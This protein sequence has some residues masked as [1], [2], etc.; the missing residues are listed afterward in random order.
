MEQYLNS[1]DLEFLLY[2]LLDTE[3][4]LLR[5]RY[6]QHSRAV[7]DATLEAAQDIAMKYLAPHYQKGDANEPCFDGTRV[8]VIAETKVAWDVLSEAGFLGAHCDEHEGGLQVPEIVCRAANAYF[9]AAN[10]PTAWYSFLTVGVINLIRTFGS[11]E[12]KLTFLPPLLAGRF[13]GTMALTEAGQGSALADI[14]TRAELQ[15]DG[16]WLI[17]GQKMFITA[18]DH[19]LTE[20]IVHLVL[21]RAKGAP[22]G[23]KGISLFIVPKIKLD[24][25]GA[26]GEENDVSLTGV[27][28]KM[29]VR[30]TTSTVLSFGE[31]KGAVG[32]LIGGLGKGLACMFQMMNEARIGV[33][34]NAAAIAIRGYRSSL[35]YARQR[36]QGRLPSNKDPASRQVMLVE[37]AD[38]RRMLLA[39]KAYSEGAL[40]LCLYASTLFEDEHTAP[41]HER[42]SRAGTLLGLLT[43]IVKSWPAKYGCASND[44]AI[45]VLGGAGYIREYPVE[46]LFRDQRLNPIH[47]G[48]EGIHGL[49]LLGRK[50]SGDAGAAFRL[51]QQDIRATISQ[52]ETYTVL[53]A[54]AQALERELSTL[55]S[56]TDAVLELIASDSD[57]GLANATI[58][59]DALGRVVVAWLWLRQGI[60]AADQLAA[61]DRPHDSDFYEGKLHAARYYIEWE[62]PQVGHLS[63][64]IGSGNAIPL[65]MQDAWF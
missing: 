49:D 46:Q 65:H 10:G 1:R 29:G 3:A 53:A 44:L 20:N 5:E 61:G 9:H 24:A 42:R 13:S 16:N 8:E 62:L 22:V 51:L 12:Q 31:K 11:D 26:L 27:L 32:Y 59:L 23:I 37:H 63:Q 34:L 17:V 54:L 50:I 25:N 14:T 64:L 15:P 39:Q 36:P 35:A 40:A 18:G 48:A 19:Q 57:R 4:L 30:N 6:K 55:S 58:Y 28:H 21:A 33:G 47:E 43:P 52:A 56:A 2:E 45:Q 41:T 38:V 60:I 7:F